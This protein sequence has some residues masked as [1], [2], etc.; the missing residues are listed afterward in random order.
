[1]PLSALRN[2]SLKHLFCVI[3][4]VSKE[5]TIK[6]D[7]SYASLGAVLTQGGQPGAYASRALT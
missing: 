4:D 1:M 3:F 5:V 6:C 2:Q 7:S